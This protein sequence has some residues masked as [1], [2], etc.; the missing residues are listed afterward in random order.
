MKIGPSSFIA[1]TSTARLP[2]GRRRFITCRASRRK[3]AGWFSVTQRT[4]VPISRSRVA[5]GVH[6]AGVGFISTS[7]PRTSKPKLS[8]WSLW[9][10]ADIPGGI[11][12][13]TTSLCLRTREASSS[14]SCRRPTCRAI[15]AAADTP[16]RRPAMARDRVG[17]P[18]A[19]GRPS[20]RSKVGRGA[21]PAGLIR[22]A[23]A[24]VV[25]AK[26]VTRPNR[27]SG[28]QVLPLHLPGHG[29]YARLRYTAKSPR[30]G[31]MT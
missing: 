28:H 7:T 22:A 19:R 26:A 3:T 25:G 9:E 4:K 5:I 11:V 17:F 20:R 29:R 16:G 14:A 31:P 6:A 30:L 27:S 18:L 10:R 13:E 24:I 1:T 15:R 23:R 8:D 21:L 12:L 2:F